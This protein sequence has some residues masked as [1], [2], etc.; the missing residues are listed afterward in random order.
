MRVALLAAAP[1]F[2]AVVAP[3]PEMRVALLAAAP[4]FLA[5]VALLP[6]MRV[7]LLAVVV[8]LNGMRIIS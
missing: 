4:V 6:E 8:P 7:A 2:L 1:V 5:V 3:L